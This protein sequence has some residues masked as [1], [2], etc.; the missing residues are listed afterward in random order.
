M[1]GMLTRHITQKLHRNIA[2]VPALALL[3]ARQVGKT[4]LAKTIAKGMDTIYLDLE[5]PGD[6]LKLSD[7][8]SFS[9]LLKKAAIVG[10]FLLGLVA[11]NSW[12]EDR[13]PLEVLPIYVHMSNGGG[14]S[15]SIPGPDALSEGLAL[16]HGA[17]ALLKVPG[18]RY[19]LTVS[20]L[21]PVI[22]RCGSAQYGNLRCEH[23][24]IGNVFGDQFASYDAPPERELMI[25]LGHERDAS[26]YQGSALLG[27]LL[28]PEGFY[29]GGSVLQGVNQWWSWV[30]FDPNDLHWSTTSCSIWSVP[31]KVVIAHELGHCFGLY[32]TNSDP[33]SDGV[34]LRLDLMSNDDEGGNL[35]I[36]WLKPSNVQRVQTHFRDLNQFRSVQSVRENAITGITLD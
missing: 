23:D 18:D 3:G 20:D 13:L 17:M 4:T 31:W 9:K 8:T 15:D 36:D 12:A 7:A 14:T 22:F 26:R 33:N 24:H 19:D 30:G 27:L 16:V 10:W 32:H 1:Q 2:R 6:L 29:W 34:D 25:R 5:A 11:V 21:E 28:F 35:S